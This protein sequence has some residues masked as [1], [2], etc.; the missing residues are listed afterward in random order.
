MQFCCTHLELTGFHALNRMILPDDIRAWDVNILLLFL[1]ME[2][3]FGLQA[4][5]SKP[6]RFF[7]A[8]VL[9]SNFESKTLAEFLVRYTQGSMR[10]SV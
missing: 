1:A 9:S 2:Q 5:A 4:R 8:T 3:S 10:G 6:S 7:S